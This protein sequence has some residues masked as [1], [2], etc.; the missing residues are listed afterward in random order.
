MAI[1]PGTSQETLA[2]TGDVWVGPAWGE[3]QEPIEA[4]SRG[5]A[6]T[7]CDGRSLWG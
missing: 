7:F 1:E 6:T 2:E 5:S 4:G 3:K